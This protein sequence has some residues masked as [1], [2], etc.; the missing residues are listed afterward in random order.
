MPAA[1]L[2]AFHIIYLRH[3]L[4][5]NNVSD[6][7][8]YTMRVNI[9]PLPRTAEGQVWIII[10]YVVVLSGLCH[11]VQVDAAEGDFLGFSLSITVIFGLSFLVASFIL[12][13][14]AEKASK[15]LYYIYT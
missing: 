1:A 9:H 8:A 7:N 14:V 15:V 5:L 11:Y 13:P 2:N 10:C 6:A 4:E 3:I 12:F